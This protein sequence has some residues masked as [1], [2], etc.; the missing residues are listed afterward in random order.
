MLSQPCLQEAGGADPPFTDD[1]SN[2]VIPS[3]TP[4]G[5]E[6]IIPTYTFNCCANVT[7]WSTIV[8]PGGGGHSN[9]V[10]S[11]GFLVYRPIGTA[12]RCYSEVGKNN[13]PSVT[14]SNGFITEPVQP[15]DYITVQPGDVAGITIAST[16]GGNEGIQLDETLNNNR[17]Y[18]TATDSLAALIPGSCP[19][20]DGGTY[21]RVTAAPMLRVSLGKS[22]S[23]MRLCIL[24]I[25]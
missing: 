3:G 4:E 8:Q 13:F 10:Y 1:N 15:S 14:V 12:N 7:E 6:A 2:P 9:G 11:V 22:Q 18:Y 20:T 5:V 25:F 23:M 19:T 21:T 17:V 16:N 24:S